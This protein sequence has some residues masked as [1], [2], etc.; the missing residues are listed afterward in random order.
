MKNSVIITA[1][2]IW[3]LLS[4]KGE[5]NIAGV[6]RALKEKSAI[7]YQGIGWLAREDKIEYRTAGAKVFISLIH[8]P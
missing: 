8:E 1:G 6:P 3:K 4:E 5:M 2:K 7:V